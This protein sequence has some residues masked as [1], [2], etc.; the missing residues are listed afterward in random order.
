LV[1]RSLIRRLVGGLLG[2]AAMSVV[3]SPK[4]K[5]DE[6]VPDLDFLA[7]LGSWQES[8]EEW[9][10]VAEWEGEERVKEDTQAAAKRKDDEN[11]T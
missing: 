10:A 4:A 11:E 3:V 7:Y 2:V 8:D 1:D 9:L 6:E 5:A